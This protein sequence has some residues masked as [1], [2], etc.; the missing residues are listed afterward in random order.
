MNR[1]VI[2]KAAVKMAPIVDDMIY[3]VFVSL[4]AR[5]SVGSSEWCGGFVD[6]TVGVNKQFVCREAG[7]G[8]KLASFL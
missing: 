3:S 5:R 4:E 7:R 6:I 8:A 1:K 2:K